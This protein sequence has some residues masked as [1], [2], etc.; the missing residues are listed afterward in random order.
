M[1]SSSLE[2]EGKTL[3]DFGTRMML[4]MEIAE[5]LESAR[6]VR[7]EREREREG[8]DNDGVLK[9]KCSWAGKG[10]RRQKYLQ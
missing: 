5:R 3:S 4:T 10:K 8:R 1:S 2:R 6:E 7:A 9:D